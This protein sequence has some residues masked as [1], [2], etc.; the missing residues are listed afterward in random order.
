MVLRKRKREKVK[1]TAKARQNHG[2]ASLKTTS[3]IEAAG[4]KISQ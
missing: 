3:A 4:S 2:I 1:N